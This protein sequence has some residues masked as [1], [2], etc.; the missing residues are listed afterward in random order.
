MSLQPAFAT[1]GPILGLVGEMPY[2][3]P[4]VAGTRVM[5]V[6]HVVSVWTEAEWAATPAYRRPANAVFVGGRFVALTPGEIGGVN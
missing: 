2:P 5:S 4:S 1:C 3:F 6:D